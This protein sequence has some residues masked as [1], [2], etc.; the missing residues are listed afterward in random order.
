MAS[1]DTSISYRSKLYLKLVQHELWTLVWLT[2][3]LVHFIRPPKTDNSFRLPFVSRFIH[4]SSKDINKVTGRA[5]LRHKIVVIFEITRLGQSKRNWSRQLIT[6]FSCSWRC[7]ELKRT[8]KSSRY[9][10]SNSYLSFE[11]ILLH[12]TI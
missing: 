3:I 8:V 9:T 12:N 10:S 11:K 6:G 1:E 4:A 2:L 5:F 7:L